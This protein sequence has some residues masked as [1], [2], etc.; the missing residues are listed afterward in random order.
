MLSDGPIGLTFGV[1]NL[2]VYVMRILLS[3]RS[4]FRRI[5]I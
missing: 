1:N 3:F 2:G 5:S 4:H